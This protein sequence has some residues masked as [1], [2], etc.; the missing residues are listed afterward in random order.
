MKKIKLLALMEESFTQMLKMKKN[1]WIIAI[2]I[3]FLSGGFLVSDSFDEDMYLEDMYE[4]MYYDEGYYEEGIEVLDEEYIGLEEMI[5][6]PVILSIGLFAV[7]IVLVVGIVVML[8]VSIASYYLYKVICETISNETLETAPL[9]EVIKVNVNITLK[10]ILGLIFFVI[11]GIIIGV[12]YAPANYVL[13]KNPQLSS[14]EVLAETR[15]LSKGF[16]WKIF[17]FNLAVAIVIGVVSFLGSMNALA[18]G[19]IVLDVL[20]TVVTFIIETVGM[21]YLS[22]FNIKLFKIIEEIKN[23]IDTII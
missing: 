11:P 9:I 18:P 6:L 23:P 15:N 20:S 7:G 19:H 17:L 2:I 22:I 21:V 13:A 10:T 16:K 12:K 3:T 5:S 14:K 4:G 8:L 1:V